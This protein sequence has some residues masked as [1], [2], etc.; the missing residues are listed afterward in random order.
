MSEELHTALLHQAGRVRVHLVLRPLSAESE[1]IGSWKNPEGFCVPSFLDIY[2]YSLSQMD[3]DKEDT[4]GVQMSPR[5]LVD[6][7]NQQCMAVSMSSPWKESLNQNQ[8]FK[9]FEHDNEHSGYPEKSLYLL[10]KKKVSFTILRLHI[11][12]S[13]NGKNNFLHFWLKYVFFIWS[14][15][16]F[17]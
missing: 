5:V 7:K 8:T 14:L 2:N 16:S 15:N 1:F 10:K 6:E 12:K 17:C 11:L 3:R 9:K 4:F 13:S